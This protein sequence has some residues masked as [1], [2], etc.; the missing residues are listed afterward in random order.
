MTRRELFKSLIS[1]LIIPFIPKSKMPEQHL[2]YLNDKPKYQPTQKQIDF[3]K[4]EDRYYILDDEQ[5]PVF[6]FKSGGS[7]T[8]SVEK[9]IDHDNQIT[10]IL[11]SNRYHNKLGK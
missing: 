2:T 4:L 11:M 8:F 10:H 1:G 5:Y 6:K 3:L 7:M 9:I